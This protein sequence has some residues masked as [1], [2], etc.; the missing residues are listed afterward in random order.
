MA[1]EVLD[2]SLINSPVGIGAEC[3]CATAY[4]WKC[5]RDDHRPSS[6]E[7]CEKWSAK[8]SSESENALWILANTKIC[9]KCKVAIEK[10]QGCN[11]VSTCRLRARSF[12]LSSLLVC[13]LG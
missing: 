6:C 9:P 4:C 2:E 7:Q 12:A 8:N 1:S 10:N 13:S 11:H 5:K 3:K